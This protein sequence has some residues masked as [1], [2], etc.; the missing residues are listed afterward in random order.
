MRVSDSGMKPATARP[1]AS[2]GSD[3]PR[4]LYLSYDGVSDPL[5][6][7]QVVPYLAALVREGY[8]AHLVSFEKP[9]RLGP[10][11]GELERSLARAGIH[12]HPLSYT[13]RP[14]V[15]STVWD[16][17]RLSR[18]AVR[19]S[20]ERR[21][22]LVHC[23]SY[24][25]A[26]VGLLLRR[27]FGTRFLFDM[28]GF[29][30][31]EKVEGGSW[32]PRHVVYGRVYRY[33]KGRETEFL[34]NADAIVSLTHAGRR[35][36]VGRPEYAGNPAPVSVIPCC[37][38]YGHFA[39]QPEEVRR[40]AREELGIE[41]GSLVVAYLG[42]LGT[43]YLLDEMLDWFSVM[44]E[45]EAESRFLFLTYEPREA[46]LRRAAERGVDPS[47]VVV[48]AA[49]RGELPYLLSAADVGISFIRP[50]YSKRASS[51]TKLGE[52]FAMGLPVVTNAGVGDVAEVVAEIGGGVVLTE[53]DEQGYRRSVEQ[54]PVFLGRDAAELRERA[55]RV[56]GLEHGVAAYA[57]LYR[58]L[59]KGESIRA[60]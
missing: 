5:G 10:V 23:R 42:S 27:R 33:F 19:L 30:A 13:K 47:A 31:D 50:T 20:R 37:A 38:D 52:Y 29:W 21:F 34:A 1:D 60:S 6:Q 40:A 55:R 36:I 24:I 57:D 17:R 49:S 15:L 12:W 4:V 45:S 3:P 11:R 53:L 26:I 16:L 35:E 9:E 8:S 25:T 14:P 18:L 41:P 51:P 58:L 7:S 59:L 28:R 54:L 48:R 22:D 2:P 44:Q 32:D 46:V 43:W 39:P 56:Y